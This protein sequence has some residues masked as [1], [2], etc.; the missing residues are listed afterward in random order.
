MSKNLL[1]QL[2]YPLLLISFLVSNCSLAIASDFDSG[3]KLYRQENYLKARK[4]LE[5]ARSS[6]NK[7]WRVYYYL[8]NTYLALG[9]FES[10][11]IE[12]EN[13]QFLCKDDRDL[14]L[15]VN[16]RLA[17]ENYIT[18]AQVVNSHLRSFSEESSKNIEA[19]RNSYKDRIKSESEKQVK[20][21]RNQ[22][23]KQIEAEKA[24]SQQVFRYDDG[25]MRLGITLE[26]E[27]Q[28]KDEAERQCEIIKQTAENSMGTFK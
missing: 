13:A 27:Q 2:S 16:A 10:A 24:C 17:V 14:K 1:A 3:L 20:M 23:A 22:A 6:Q 7:D 26:R 12:Y 9:K 11:R 18:E 15:C 19:A 8:G 21:I 25:V 5:K 28:I 4:L